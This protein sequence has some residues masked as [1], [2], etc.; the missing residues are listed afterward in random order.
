MASNEQGPKW[1]KYLTSGFEVAVGIALGCVV[2]TY[3]DKKM[4][5]SP[6]GLLIGLLLGCA[7]GMYLLIKE[8]IKMNK[9]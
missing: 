4:G 2:G 3:V 6:W 5:S 7:G 9:D 8:A 1:S